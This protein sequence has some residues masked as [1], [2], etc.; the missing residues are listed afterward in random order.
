MDAVLGAAGLRTSVHYFPPGDPRFAGADSATLAREVAGLIRSAGYSIANL[1]LTLL[2][3]RPRIEIARGRDASGDRRAVSSSNPIAWDSRRRRSRGSARSVAA[4][5]SPARR[6]CCS[7]AL[8]NGVSASASPLRALADGLAP[9]GERAHGAVQ[10]ARR[11]GARAGRSCCASRTPTPI[12]SRRAPK[13][14]ILE[15]PALA[16]AHLGRGARIGGAY[17]P[18]RQSERR[19]SYEEAAGRL[20][21]AGGVSVVSART[22]GDRC[23][24]E[25]RTR[26]AGAPSGHRGRLSRDRGLRKRS[27]RSGGRGVTRCGFACRSSRCRAGVA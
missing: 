22:P 23:R 4:R 6:S 21:D 15:R 10:L 27:S 26:S 9:S 1:D 3:E 17:G 25:A 16:R 13:R 8:G 14:G 24:R 7:N 2:A 12:A 11:A 20:L 5:G 18:Y 19:A